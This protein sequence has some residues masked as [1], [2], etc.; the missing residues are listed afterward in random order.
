MSGAGS[1]D[2]ESFWRACKEQHPELATVAR[3][4]VWRFGDSDA[5]CDELLALVLAGRKTATAG[6]LWDFE[7]GNEPMPVPGGYSIVTDSRGRPACL[8][9]TTEVTVRPYADVP[10][11]FAFDEGEGDRTLESWRRGHWAYFTRRCQA[12]AR[13]AE[14]SMPV[15]CERF[16]LVAR[17]K[18]PDV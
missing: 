16:R 18:L 13:P 5:L 14:P 9:Q 4:D 6:L 11:A 7:V 1:K 17:A 12:L 2:I 8:L 10:A 15:V 3:Y